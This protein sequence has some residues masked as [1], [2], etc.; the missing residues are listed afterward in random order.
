MQQLQLSSFI[1]FNTVTSVL[2][3]FLEWDTANSNHSHVE[4]FGFQFTLFIVQK[5]LMFIFPADPVETFS[6]G[7]VTQIFILSTTIVTLIMGITA[8]TELRL[9][10]NKGIFRVVEYDIE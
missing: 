4:Q 9:H 10:M 2:L 7:Q 3:S 6:E 5:S 1:N 8:I